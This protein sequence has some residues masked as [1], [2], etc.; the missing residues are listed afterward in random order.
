LESVLKLRGRA[1]FAEPNFGGASLSQVLG[2]VL[3]EDV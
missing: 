2:G 1:L 3:M